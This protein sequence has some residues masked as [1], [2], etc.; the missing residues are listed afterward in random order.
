MSSSSTKFEEDWREHFDNAPCGYLSSMVDGTIVSVNQTFLDWTGYS[1]NELLHVRKFQQLLT[2]PGQI[3][4]ETHYAPLLQMQGFVK[5]I[6]FD[7]V[8]KA[9][10][11][12]PVLVN[13]TRQN[14]T[15]S[16]PA[17]IRSSFFDATDRRGYERELLDAR[18]NLEETVQRRTLELEKQIV[19][20]KKAEESL[21]DLTS[22]LL[23]LRDDE[24]RR[25]A[26]DLHDSAGQLLSASAMS[27]DAASR[28]ANTLKPEVVK[29]IAEARDSVREALK[30]IRIVSYLLHPPLLD[31]SGLGSAIRLFL[32]GFS[33]RGSI[34][35]EF[36][37]SEEFG[38]LPEDLEIAVFRVVQE[39]LTNVHR[40]SDCKSAVVKLSRLP[41][42]VRVEITDDGK[43][44]SAELTLG[45]G[46]RG[47][48]E[49]VE[50][51]GGKL[52]IESN[53]KGT[54]V[55]AMIPLKLSPLV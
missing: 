20:R 36:I 29:S 48:R 34:S 5:E 50:Q 8:C 16:R 38:R 1:R 21:K 35:T 19:D 33:G 32:E 49:R 17:F 28:H 11:P 47:M 9:R 54:T 10:E 7:L 18:R 43:G 4:Y 46:L 30:E 51:L 6:A 45:V 26:R 23:R 52:E 25:I 24:R 39:C 37:I 41:D 13:S 53:S 3:F 12:L 14:G 44:M 22:R 31:E 42:K 55:R 2:I 40:H 15:D 27:L